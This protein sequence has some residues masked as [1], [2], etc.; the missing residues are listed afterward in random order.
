M[1]V[2]F[3]RC[4]AR[5]SKMANYCNVFVR[6]TNRTIVAWTVINVEPAIN[7]EELFTQ[8]K[9][10]VFSTIPASLE[11]SSS[12]LDSVY[13]GKDKS[14]ANSTVDRKI[15]VISVCSLFGWHI[16]FVV[17]VP[18]VGESSSNDTVL[19]VQNAFTVMMEVQHHICAPA[20]P[21]PIPEYNKKDKL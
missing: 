12:V 21:E 4:R 6:T 20:L 14:T 15:N 19:T 2:I 16:K 7:F 13:I 11:L 18:E 17:S 3:S 10:G 1:I 8:I 9:S 5:F